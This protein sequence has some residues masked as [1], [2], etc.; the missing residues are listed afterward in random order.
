MSYTDL[1]SQERYALEQMLVYGC[2]YC[3]I[4]R[5]LGRHRSTIQREIDR[6]GAWV[7]CG[8]GPTSCTVSCRTGHSQYSEPELIEQVESVVALVLET[9]FGVRIV[10]T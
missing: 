4:G 5:R 9:L 7:I 2:S 3:E 6:N 10:E 1:T 8:C